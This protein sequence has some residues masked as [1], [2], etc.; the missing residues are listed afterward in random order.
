MSPGHQL[1]ALGI[2]GIVVS[3]DPEAA[4]LMG[5]DPLDPTARAASARAGFDQAERVADAVGAVW[6]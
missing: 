3:P 1:A 4:A 5:S 2:P 6:N